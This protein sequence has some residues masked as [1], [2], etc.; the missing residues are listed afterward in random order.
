M[1][2]PIGEDGKKTSDVDEERRKGRSEERDRERDGEKESKNTEITH[3][4]IRYERICVY[5]CIYVYN[6]YVHHGGIEILMCNTRFHS[7]FG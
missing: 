3:V 6:S 4:E 1:E 2:Q 7:S 5:F